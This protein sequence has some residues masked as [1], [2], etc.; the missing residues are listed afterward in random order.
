MGG[1]DGDC[2]FI[3]GSGSDRGGGKYDYRGVAATASVCIQVA[4][5]LTKD[6]DDMGGDD[7]DCYVIQG[8]GSARGGGKDTNRD[9]AATTSGTPPEA[10]YSQECRPEIRTIQCDYPARGVDHHATINLNIARKTRCTWA[11][12]N[13]HERATQ[14]KDWTDCATAARSPG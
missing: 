12:F 4:G 2:Y 7:D 1:D 3:R 6:D 10:V 8:S 14:P 9:V 5:R 13:K 11:S